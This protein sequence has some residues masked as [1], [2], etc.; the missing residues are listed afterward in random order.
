MKPWKV[1]LGAVLAS[2][3]AA[4][5][6]EPPPP[7]E[8]VRAVKTIVVSE[9]AGGQTRRFPGVVEAV[10]R[11]S[12]SFEVSGI[13]QEVRV[14]AGDRIQ[15]GQVLAVL[16]PKPFELSVTSA[17]AALSRAQAQV[18]EKKS[19]YDRERRIFAEDPGATTQKRIEQARAAF[20]SNRQSV[21]YA[22]AQLDL[23]RRDLAN[24]RLLAPFDGTVASRGVEPSEQVHR[25]QAILDLFSERAMQVAVQIPEAVIEDVFVGQPA[26]MRFPTLGGRV[27]HGAITE[28]GSAAQGTNAFPVKATVGASNSQIRPGITAELSLR[29]P[30]RAGD[31]S[32]LVPMTAVAPGQGEA[33]WSV[34][35][36]DPASSTVRRINVAGGELI[37]NHVAL[38][39]GVAAGDIV[40][41]AG[42]SFLS[43]GQKVR[44]LETAAPAS[45]G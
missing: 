33:M 19:D 45:G 31:D 13:V 1:A 41:I 22:R 26:Q 24:T 39:E 28:V 4:C 38:T 21:S 6:E 29:L 11:S 16:D 42:V 5:G 44:L 23:A 9:R 35:V 8:R 18:E 34:F 27:F 40:V 43:D 36:F 37:G 32:Y 14:D 25:G 20:E 10:D 15:A 30:G 2:V 3:L 12:I 17:E 7:P